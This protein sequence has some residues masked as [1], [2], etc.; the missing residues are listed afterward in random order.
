MLPYRTLAYF[1]YDG[2]KN[3]LCVNGGDA[4]NFINVR[5]CLPETASDVNDTV[6]N[7]TYEL[8]LIQSQPNSLQDGADYS[9]K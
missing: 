4:I 3:F 1:A 8:E 9:Y 6:C 5:S 2:D 7:S